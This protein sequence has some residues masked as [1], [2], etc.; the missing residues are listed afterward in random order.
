MSSQSPDHSVADQLMES[1]QADDAESR[2]PFARPPSRA[3]GR[4]QRPDRPLR[5]ACPDQRRSRAMIDV[6]LAAGADLN[7]MSQ[8]WAG[9]FGLLHIADP[10]LAAYAIER[11]A[12]VD[13]HA[14]ARLGKTGP[15]AR[16]LED[17]PQACMPAAAMARLRSTSPARSRSPPTCSTMARTSTHATSTTNPPPR[18]TC[19]AIAR[20]WPATWSSGVA[21][22]TSSWRRP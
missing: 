21:R 10:E 4:N 3:E 6:L 1:I 15:P 12:V 9:G 11:G 18:S 7:A 19:S 22:P 16:A 5:F 14:A 17:D 8:W 2:P 20:T 13:I